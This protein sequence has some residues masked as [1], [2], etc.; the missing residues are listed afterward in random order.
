MIKLSLDFAVFFRYFTLLFQPQNSTFLRQVTARDGWVSVKFKKIHNENDSYL[1]V[2]DSSEGSEEL[3][4]DV[5]LGLRGEVVDENAPAG[6]VGGRHT[7]Q[8]RVARQ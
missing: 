4:E 1:D 7:R 6:P 5:L 2:L 8:Q 3:P